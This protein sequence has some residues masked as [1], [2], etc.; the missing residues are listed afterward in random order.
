MPAGQKPGHAGRALARKR[1]T[2]ARQTTDDN[3]VDRTTPVRVLVALPLSVIV[4]GAPGGT[5]KAARW[6]P[7]PVADKARLLQNPFRRVREEGSP[8]LGA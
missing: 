8:L 4:R 1:K 7:Y 3:L 2:R 6:R 5:A